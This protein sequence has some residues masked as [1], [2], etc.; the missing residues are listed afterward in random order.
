MWSVR[1]VSASTACSSGLLPTSSPRRCTCAERDDL[2]DDVPLLV[3]LDGVDRGVAAGVVELS[4]AF[5]TAR[6]HLDARAQDVG[7]AEQQRQADAL[8]LQV[9]GELVEV[10]PAVRLLGGVHGDVAPAR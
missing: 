1:S 2:L 5:G 9:H 6:Q 3:H 4:M 7:E 10:Q 8:R